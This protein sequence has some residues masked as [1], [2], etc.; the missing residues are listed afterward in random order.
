MEVYNKQPLFRPEVKLPDKHK[1]EKSMKRDAAPPCNNHLSLH[2]LF[3]NQFPNLEMSFS[4]G[5]WSPIPPSP[6]SQ[7]LI[8]N[9]KSELKAGVSAPH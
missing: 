3:S 5:E 8:L 7:Q 1:H 2:I 9:C 4:A 6:G